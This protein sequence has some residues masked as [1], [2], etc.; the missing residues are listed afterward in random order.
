MLDD[1]IEQ[2]HIM[3]TK[4]TSGGIVGYAL[5]RRLYALSVLAYM[6]ELNE[7]LS[8][9]CKKLDTSLDVN[10]LIFQYDKYLNKDYWYKGWLLSNGI[11]L[12]ADITVSDINMITD[13][14]PNGVKGY[15]FT[16]D[17]VGTLKTTIGQLYNEDR[18]DER[19]LKYALSKG[20]DTMLSLLVDI[21]KKAQTPPSYLFVKFWEDEIIGPVDKND[22]IKT[23]KKWKDE[24]EDVN[25]QNLKDRQTQILAKFLSSD[26]LKYRLTPTKGEINRCQLSIEDESLE[27]GYELP[28]NIREQCA[29]FEFFI[30]WKDNNHYILGLNYEKIGKYIYEHYS[31]S[32]DGIYSLIEL[33]ILL[34]AI[35]EDMASLKPQL[36]QYLKGY[37]EEQVN[38]LLN[39]CSDILNTCKIHLA[40][41]INDSFL[42]TYLKR[43]LFNK[44][45]KDEAR[46]KLSGQSR[47]TFV[48]EMVAVLKNAKIFKVECDKHD[49]AKSLSEKITRIKL[50]TI[51]KNI[52][53]AYNSN[54]GTLY[55]WTMKN[56]EDLKKKA[57]NPF[58]GII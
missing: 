57:S 53:R 44:E 21:R 35:H 30:K 32:W 14:F 55:H 2:L 28:D 5:Y 15:S 24:L 18:L 7:N 46:K 17:M 34:D 42:Y 49:L 4:V 47:N 16:S 8:N 9:L 1:F 12:G 48:C 38:V 10:A 19:S 50:E 6:S 37:E 3:M 25:F 52:E 11:N 23:Y 58:A 45:M 33:D 22:Y 56:I 26:F 13:Y 51:E 36:K 41:E 20:L 43:L 27:Y 29:R 40:K 31:D 39:E 54:E